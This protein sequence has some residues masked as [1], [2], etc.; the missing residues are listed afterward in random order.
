MLTATFREA[1]VPK[2]TPEQPSPSS[3]LC[4]HYSKLL[5][6]STGK[7]IIIYL[8]ENVAVILNIFVD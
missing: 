8:P 2:A 3:D 1:I 6:V 4:V 7:T 5:E